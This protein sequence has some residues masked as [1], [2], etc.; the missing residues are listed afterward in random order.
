MD[1][2]S[3]ITVVY[4]N[5]DKIRKTIE[6]CLS[7]TWDNIEYIVIDGGSKDGT[8]NIIKEYISKISYF[9][10]EPDNGLYDAL[11]KGISVSTGD[12]ILVLNSGD[13]FCDSKSL[14]N[15]MLIDDIEHV[16]VI[17]GNSKRLVNGIES[18][19]SASN[20]IED[21]RF[22]PIYR[23]GSSLVRASLHKKYL[24]RLEKTKQFG[25]GLDYDVIFR[26]YH[27]KK[28]FKMVDVYIQTFEL[29]GISNNPLKSIK[30]NYKISSQ[31]G[32]N[33]DK[34]KYYMNCLYSYYKNYLY[35]LV[36][37]KSNLIKK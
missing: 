17:Y 12:W 6:S 2:I 32:F 29:D 8:V 9:V 13:Y 20:N 7:Q 31:Y 36:T 28:V 14:E 4:N 35:L 33:F 16:D 1:K 21:L 10:S 23:H 26:L 34:F 19:F 18:D 15:A 22:H 3:V 11:N 30:I 37:G 27:D 24:F 5:V 25:Y